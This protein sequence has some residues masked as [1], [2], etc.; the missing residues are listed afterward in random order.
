LGLSVGLQPY[1]NDL[2]NL[3]LKRVLKKAWD[4]N[5]LY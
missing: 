5:R 3:G 2:P 1:E 4:L